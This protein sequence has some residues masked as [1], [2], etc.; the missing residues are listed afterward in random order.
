MD[1]LF[2]PLRRFKCTARVENLSFT[3]DCGSLGWGGMV[4]VTGRNI[5]DGGT[6]RGRR[7]GVDTAVGAQTFKAEKGPRG[8]D[9]SGGRRD[10]WG[11]EGNIAGWG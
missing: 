11:G 2:F 3:E 1:I 4:A 10:P 6:Q 8:Q 5:R 7:G 9:A